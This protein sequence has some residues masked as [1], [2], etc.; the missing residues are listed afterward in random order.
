MQTGLVWATKIIT[1]PFNDV[2]IYWKSPLY[3]MRGELIDPMGEVEAD[4][5]R[6]IGPEAFP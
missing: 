1:D 2:K 6:A 5:T 3:L 4:R